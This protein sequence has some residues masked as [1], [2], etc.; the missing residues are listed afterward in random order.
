MS[1][2]IAAPA[3]RSSARLGLTLRAVLIAPKLGFEAAV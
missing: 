3:T 2:E 1:R